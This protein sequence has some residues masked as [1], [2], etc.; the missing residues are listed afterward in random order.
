MTRALAIS[1]LHKT[2]GNGFVA[3]R[4]IDLHVEQGD[5][6]ALLG[7]NGAGKSTVIGIITSLINKSSGK[8]HIYGYDI[9]SHFAEAK[10]CIGVL[11]Q[12][13]N[14]NVWDPI[15]EILVNQAGYYGI[16]RDDAY[17]RAERWLK[18]LGLWGKRRE[19]AFNLSGGMKRRMM[20]ARALMHDPRLLILD[21]PTAGVDIENRRTMWRF[22]SEINRQ[23]TTIILTTH[24][25]E[26]AENLCRH[27][28]II[29]DGEVIEHTSTKALIN[30]LGSE[31]FV[32]DIASPLRAAPVLDCHAV[33]LLDE[34]T[35][36]IDFDKGK[37]INDV[38]SQL[39]TLGVE[40]LSMRNKTNRL[41]QLFIDMVDDRNRQT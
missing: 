17:Q 24:Y 31:T 4:G 11:P 8:V 12:E 41:E 3:L 38:F 14:F 5:F 16:P 9:D 36:E 23:G 27:I 26:E 37:G 33:R 22:L 35:M 29:A 18:Q 30:R 10:A 7:P 39:S 1:G 20:V 19:I 25:L 40:V 13:F 15:E 6:F 34:T 21:E 28:A 2:Y 32:L